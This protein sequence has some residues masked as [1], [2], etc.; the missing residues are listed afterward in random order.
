M[1]MTRRQFIA[2]LGGAS[3]IFAVDIIPGA[4][5]NSHGILSDEIEPECIAD[6]TDTDYTNWIIFEPDDK[7]RVFTGRTELGQGLK[8]VIT[9]TITQGLDIEITPPRSPLFSIMVLAAMKEERNG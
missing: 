2:T 4:E 3:L 7:V 8:T 5:V 9:A 6:Y 1:K